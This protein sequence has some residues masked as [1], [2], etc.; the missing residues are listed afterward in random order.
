MNDNNN[1][2]ELEKEINDETNKIEKIEKLEMEIKN[3]TDDIIKDVITDIKT[4]PTSWL[5]L[6]IPTTLNVL[7]IY[8]KKKELFVEIE[9]DFSEVI[10]YKMHNIQCDTT[11][12]DTAMEFH[13]KTKIT[14]YKGDDFKE[15]YDIVNSLKLK[16]EYEEEENLKLKTLNDTL[17]NIEDI[18]LK[19]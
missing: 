7:P 12:K 18:K 5:T 17:K 4:N 10:L 8:N 11:E 6:K 1:N 2:K 19:F 15:L 16:R 3:K 13:G 9:T 14:T